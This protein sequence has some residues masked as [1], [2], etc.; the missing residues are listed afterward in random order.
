MEMTTPTLR[1][2]RFAIGVNVLVQIGAVLLLVVM[3]N[4]IASRHYGRLDWTKSGYYKLSDKTK[5]VLTSLK[6]PV[7]VIVYLPPRLSSD[8]GEKTLEDVRHLLREFETVGKDKL[9][10][11]YVDTDRDR[12]RAEDLAEKYKFDEPNVVIF[13]SGPRHKFVTLRDIVEMDFEPTG[14]EPPR[15]K[16]FKGEGV[17]LSALQTVTEEQPATVY[18]LT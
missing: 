16:A 15:V 5:Q 10:V 11:E 4:W 1:K 12:K 9:Q 3:V 18:F 17:F 6:Q 14:L 13:V 7:Q 2:R 8:S